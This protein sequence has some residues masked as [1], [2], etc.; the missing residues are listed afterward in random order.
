MNDVKGKYRIKLERLS[1]FDS[2]LRGN[3]IL[4]LDVTCL[5]E[6]KNFVT[7]TA[8]TRILDYS[9]ICTKIV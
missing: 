9:G 4:L 3:V 7:R 5:I 2:R 1:I 6:W 8:V